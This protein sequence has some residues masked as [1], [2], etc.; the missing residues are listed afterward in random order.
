MSAS[1]TRRRWQAPEVVQTS[2]MDCGPAALKCLLEGHGVAVNYARLREACQTSLDGT[3]IDTLEQ[4]AQQLGLPAEQVMQPLDHVALD[5]AQCLPAIAV[6]RQADGATH[7]VVLWRRVGGWLQLMD[8][9]TGRR[10]VRVA[11]FQAELLRHSMSLPEADWREWAASQENTN[12]LAERLQHLGARAAEAQALVLH[13]TAE[14]RGFEL[15]TLDAATRL[16]HSVVQGGGLPRGRGAVR[17][18]RSLL[19]HTLDSPDDVYRHLGPAYWSVVPD[20]DVAEGEARRVRVRGAVLLRVTGAARAAVASASTPEPAASSQ[21][22]PMSEALR[23]ALQERQPHPLHTI[24]QLLRQDGLLGPLAMVGAMALAAGGLVAETLL[25]RGVFEISG[26]LGGPG[27]RLLALGALVA[28]VLL[29]LAI[30][31]P[32]VTESLRYGR[33]L[34][35]RLRMALLAKLPKLDDR[36]FQS[37]SVPDMAERN[38]SIQLA[39]N[40]P[41]LGLNFVQTTAELLLTLLALAVIAPA[42]VPWA[43]GIV[44]VA[45]AVPALL[46]PLLNERDLRLR[47]HGAALNG[48]YLDA[49]LGAV[50]VRTHRAQ[51]AVRRQHEGLLVAWVQASRST[52]AAGVAAGTLQSA[53]CLGLAAALLVQHFRSAAGITGG[54][55]L[56]VYWALKLPALGSS[57][58]ALARQYPAQRN[59]LMRLFEPL[60]APEALQNL[61]TERPASTDR[62]N[63]V[64][65]NARSPHALAIAIEGGRVLAGGHEIL[66]DLHLHIAPG[67]HVAVVG[68]SGAGKSSLVGLL[69]GWHTLAEGRLQVDGHALHADAQ[70]TLRR[71]TAWVDPGVQ[72]WNRSFLDNLG[73]ASGDEALA[74]VGTVIEAAQLRGV[75]QKLPQ[76]LQSPLGEGGALL[77]GG[78]GQRVRLGRAML[79]S[80]VRLALLDE[81]FRGLDREQ[82]RTL[83]ATS[84]RWWAEQTLLCVTHDVG[85]TLQFPRV[86]VV[87]DGRIVEDGHPAT[88]A[89]GDTHYA[90]L[91]QAEDELRRAMWSTDSQDEATTGALW[92]PVRIEAGLAIDGHAA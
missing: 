83:L 29:L 87:D 18:V 5:A 91:L 71:E 31:L 89:A 39:R 48:F 54:D 15:A 85:E 82:R 36:Y 13:A 64:S 6:V 47:N 53:L 37:R 7:F 20:L 70:E 40:V 33:H 34:E 35:T 66:R 43:M 81:P 28:F 38:H 73:Y 11:D 68:A 92:R 45:V 74:R 58:G 16:A 51:R 8:P 30:E 9:A 3:S 42:S 49:L 56:L 57:V 10:W 46:Q 12:A 25:F 22:Q 44:A 52:L 59:V 88:L 72:L 75:L 32:I 61:A 41:M 86:L 77:S 76:G 1:P 79:Q 80:G 24:W 67:E 23:A 21:Q 26:L 84:R 17:L 65:V 14:P 63:A 50:P 60:T 55:L 27:Q 4:V 62:G 69:L 78:E 2:A 19:Q 90:R